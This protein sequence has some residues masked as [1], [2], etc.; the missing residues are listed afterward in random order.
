[1]EATLSILNFESGGPGGKAGEIT[2]PRSLN[3]C[4]R[5]GFDPRE[6]LPLPIDAFSM[7]AD[8]KRHLT[9]EEQKIKYSHFEARRREKIRI[10]RSEYEE[11]IKALAKE[12]QQL[13]RGGL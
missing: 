7:T 1:M 3:A 11:V 12:G 5:V 2:S 6:L 8:H 13:V 4:L 10:V 9:T